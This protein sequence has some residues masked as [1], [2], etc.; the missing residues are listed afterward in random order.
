[1]KQEA[2]K[3][4][5]PRIALYSLRRAIELDL[6]HETYGAY[7]Y[8]ESVGHAQMLYRLLEILPD[9]KPHLISGSDDDRGTYPAFHAACR[10]GHTKLLDKTLELLPQEQH[11]EM[12]L[13]KREHGHSGLQE[14]VAKDRVAFVIT[15]LEK[16]GDK[17][18]ELIKQDDYL[19]LKL[20]VEKGLIDTVK[21]MLNKVPVED[22]ATASSH[23]PEKWQKVLDDEPKRHLL[24]Q[25]IGKGKARWHAVNRGKNPPEGVKADIT[26][27]YGFSPKV[28]GEL[29]PFMEE[30]AKAEG[31]GRAEYRAYK[32]A[33]LFANTQEAL[34]YL[35]EYSQANS[36]EKQPI[37]D[38][39]LFELPING[40]WNITRWKDSV[41]KYGDGFADY[42]EHAAKVDRVIAEE[43][44]PFPESPAKLRALVSKF[45]YERGAERPDIACVALE[46]D[47]SEERFNMALDFLKNNKKKSDNLPEVFIDGKSL[48]ENDSSLNQ[49]IAGFYM[50]KLE[51][52]DP[53]A[54]F[55]GDITNCCQS[56]GK[57]GDPF[58]RHGASSEDGGFYVWKKKTDGKITQ[59]DRIIA[60]SW[61]WVSQNNAVTFDSF[62]RLGSDYNFLLKPF[63]ERFEGL[64]T[65]PAPGYAFQKV[66]IGKGGETPEL[67]YP[68]AEPP[69]RPKDFTYDGRTMDALYDSKAQYWV[70]RTQNHRT[71]EI[72]KS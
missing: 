19:A 56:I 9:V 70:K 26:S 20:A 63:L 24:W 25:E 47:V 66:T 52:S 49:K 1:M 71:D 67:P 41:L 37:H 30:A 54:L 69:E 6:R 2:V 43:A 5:K 29:L 53:R 50:I 61:A 51:A 68:D 28:Y 35:R 62:E 7:F 33:V 22:K 34:R 21:L 64:A 18:S 23:I 48:L 60:Q 17:S 45:H 32:L 57:E 46:N 42:L 59:D 27:P 44:I 36:T 3:Q 55:L 15:L 31:N 11:M 4:N 38:A 40:I 16:A 12:F 72:G 10:R 13:S 58:T 8:A 65:A 39:C 14:A